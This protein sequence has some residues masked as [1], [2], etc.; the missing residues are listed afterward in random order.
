MEDIPDRVIGV[1][2]FNSLKNFNDYANVGMWVNEHLLRIWNLA[3]SAIVDHKSTN[4]SMNQENIAHDASIRSGADCA[5]MA[6]PK[7]SRGTNISGERSKE[8]LEG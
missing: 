2:T 5:V 3:K 4:R 7:S 8:K 1:G 6:P